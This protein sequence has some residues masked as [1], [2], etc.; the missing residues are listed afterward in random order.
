MRL[1]ASADLH[2][3]HEIYKW[4]VGVATEKGADVVVLAGDLLGAPSG[5]DSI[6]ESQRGV[7]DIGVMDQPS[8]SRAP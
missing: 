8:G 5:F 3:D 7:V 2:G 1:L 4:L 6:E